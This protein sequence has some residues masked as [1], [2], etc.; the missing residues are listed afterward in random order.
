ML[1]VQITLLSSAPFHIFISIHY[2]LLVQIVSVSGIKTPT[3]FQYIICCWFK[4]Y[5]S[6]FETLFLYF[7][8]LYVVGSID[9]QKPISFNPFRF[10]YIICCWFKHC[11]Y[12]ASISAPIFQYII[13]CWFNM[14]SHVWTIGIRDFNTLYVVGSMK[15]HHLKLTQ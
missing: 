5:L 3:G 10:Q 8:T 9:P 13:C 4:K 7:N 11:C 2:M 14:C 15:K 1:L 6:F 12:I